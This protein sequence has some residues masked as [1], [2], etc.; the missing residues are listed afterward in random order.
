M[1]HSN[2]GLQGDPVFVCPSSSLHGFHHFTHL[3]E[4]KRD[5]DMVSPPVDHWVYYTL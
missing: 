4:A 3:A 5:T 2:N 1:N